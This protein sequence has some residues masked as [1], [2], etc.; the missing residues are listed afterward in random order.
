MGKYVEFYWHL[1]GGGGRLSCS[2]GG[3]TGIFSQEDEEEKGDK[4]PNSTDVGSREDG[5][6]KSDNKASE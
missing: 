6:V 2:L 4:P 1:G 3:G 5:M